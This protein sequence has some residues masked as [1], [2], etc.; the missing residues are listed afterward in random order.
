MIG[1]AQPKI[2]LT[3]NEEGNLELDEAFKSIFGKELGYEVVFEY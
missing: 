3:Q 1:G 2:L